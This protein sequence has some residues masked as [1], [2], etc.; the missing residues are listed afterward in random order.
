MGEKVDGKSTEFLVHEEAIAQLSKPLYD[1]LKGGSRESQAGCTIWDDV[2]KETFEQFAQFAYTGDY[3]LSKIKKRKRDT[4]EDVHGSVSNAGPDFQL[5]EDLVEDPVPEEDYP[6]AEDP[7]QD[8]EDYEPAISEAYG[9]VRVGE[10]E[11][12]LPPPAPTPPPLAP[13]VNDSFGGWGGFSGKKKKKRHTSNWGESIGISRSDQSFTNFQSLSFPPLAS[14]NNYNGTC[15]P[16]EHF[17]RDGD[18]S[19]LFLSH[20]L[21]YVLGDLQLIDSLKAL[22]LYKLH[23][24][25]CIFELGQ[26]N[27]EDVIHLVRYVYLHDKGGATGQSNEGVG[28]LKGLV[29]KYVAANA[30]LLSFEDGFMSLL[31]E[32]GQFVKDFFKLV[33]QKGVLLN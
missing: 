21:L 5:V 25:L 29:C 22:A 14:R 13:D 20:A 15:E 28:V 17:D 26:E 11:P 3:S 4:P 12:S 31:E 27:A 2:S 33:L 7:I 8:P 10:Y 9:S 23:K 32:G 6:T 18:Y 19:D 24:T 16:V 1:L 30:S